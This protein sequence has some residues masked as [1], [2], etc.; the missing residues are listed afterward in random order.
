MSMK[1]AGKCDLTFG[2]P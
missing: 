1:C 2:L